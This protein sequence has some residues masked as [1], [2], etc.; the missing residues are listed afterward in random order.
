LACAGLLLLP[1]CIPSNVVAVEDRAVVTAA[2]VAEWRPATRAE[3][4]GLFA[5]SSITGPVAASLR[6][7]Y[8]LF[9]DDGS[10]TAAAL[11][12]EGERPEFRVL[13]G[14][15]EF[16]DGNLVLDGAEPARLESAKDLLRLSGADGTVVLR[17]EVM[18]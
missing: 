5:S 7:I 10:F 16:R 4:V 2:D 3:A 8:Y 17:R 6:A 11:V 15:W 12:H 9:E 13:S 14:A 18:P 1:G